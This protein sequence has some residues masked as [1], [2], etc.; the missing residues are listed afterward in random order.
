M[1]LNFPLNARLPSMKGNALQLSHSVWCFLTELTP[2]FKKRPSGP[3]YDF[4]RLVNRNFEG[5]PGACEN[6]I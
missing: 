1:F 6:R 5:S 3:F 4:F 2:H